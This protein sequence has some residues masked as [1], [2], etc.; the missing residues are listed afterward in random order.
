MKP[1]QYD[2]PKPDQE[3]LGM[4]SSNMG[5]K[6]GI[7]TAFGKPSKSP[8]RLREH[9]RQFSWLGSN[10]WDINGTSVNFYQLLSV[11]CDEVAVVFPEASSGE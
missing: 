8:W 1:A 4:S 10:Q 5:H 2:C 11:I 7:S 3:I 9:L 6:T